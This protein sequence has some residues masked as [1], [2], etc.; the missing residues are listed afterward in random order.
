MSYDAVHN[1]VTKCYESL[2]TIQDELHNIRCDMEQAR[3]LV[4]E[5][6]RYSHH[7]VECGLTSLA[8]DCGLLDLDIALVATFG[9]DLF[10]Q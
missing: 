2:S 10:E 6:R 9:D 5:L 3:L 1:R 8:C 7:D 4:K